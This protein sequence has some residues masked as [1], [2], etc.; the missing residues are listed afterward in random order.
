[1]EREK[2]DMNQ[3]SNEWPSLSQYSGGGKKNNLTTTKNNKD[4]HMLIKPNNSF[5]PIKN[6]DKYYDRR[7]HH[8]DGDDKT[9]MKQ[10][11]KMS[12]S[13]HQPNDLP[14]QQQSP[15][16]KND[17]KQNYWFG[18]DVVDDGDG[19]DLDANNLP[20]T[21]SILKVDDRR[22]V[23]LVGTSHFSKASHRDVR[24][25]IRKFKPQ[26]VVLEL[27]R[28]RMCFLSMSENEIMKEAKS[29]NFRK[30]RDYMKKHGF[31]Q[32]FIYTLL[33]SASARVTKDLEIAPGG[34]FRNAFNEALK[35]PGCVVMLGDRPIDITLRR[36]IATLTTWQ[37]IKITFH[38]LFNYEKLK[39]EELERYK[40]KDVLEQL[41]DEFSAEFPGLSR[42]MVD[43]RDMF[44]VDSLRNAAKTT[45]PDST[46]VGVVGIGHVAGIRDKWETENI[47]V[48]ELIKIPVQKPSKTF[49]IIKYTFYGA[50]AYSL[51]RYVIPNTV[52]NWTTNIVHQLSNQISMK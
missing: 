22:I 19:D 52:K 35:I 21:V 31:L 36:A 24:R 51:Y 46:I 13:S 49:I 39:E 14:V 4:F 3:D 27:C 16:M 9:T 29:L 37:K 28:S 30:I 18:D 45:P 11:K 12:S 40:Q 50:I 7:H 48:E 1:M 10:N 15:S 23:Y 5:T 44:L 8:H 26:V 32:T 6:D 2:N 20:E 25:V 17:N 34:E 42:V 43:E 47:N 38:C 41:V 33:L